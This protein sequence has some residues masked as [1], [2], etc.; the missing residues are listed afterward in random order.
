MVIEETQIFNLMD[1][2]G[3]RGDV[4]NAIQIYLDVLI[5]LIYN[6]N[7]TWNNLPKSTA[8]YEFYKRALS[9]SS[10]VFTQHSPYDRLCLILNS[11]REFKNAL[12][13]NNLS[14]INENKKQYA[15]LISLFD[16]GIEDRA[17]HYT[18]NLVKLGL[19][20][21]QRNISSVGRQLHAPQTIRRD[22]LENLIPI[23][24]V[25][26]IY[27][28]QLLKLKVFD[29]AQTKS[30]S[31]FYFALYILMKKQRVDEAC[32]LEMVQG[33]TPYKPIDNIDNYIDNYKEADIVNDYKVVIPNDFNNPKIML[34]EKFKLY[35]T[36]KKSKT[37]VPVYYQY[38]KNL[39]EFIENKTAANLDTLL[40]YYEKNKAMLK[41]AFGCGKNI[42]KTKTGERPNPSDFI[43]E[44]NIQNQSVLMLSM[45]I[46]THQRESSKQ[47]V[48]LV[49]I[50]VL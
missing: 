50:T 5:D 19:A 28:R 33:N 22:T 41:K 18:S 45:N 6:K 48:L 13:S 49:L 9:L 3:R 1:T 4:I 44:H 12:E 14:W 15:E 25:N 2:N 8:Q 39:Y 38:Y 24:N 31:P 16:N 17:R 7:M 11:N 43:I 47:Q 26:I 46:L 21:E 23:D 36:N 37:A 42:F 27:L 32:F 30:Y 29:K 10:D 34:E 35:F 40:D 20:D